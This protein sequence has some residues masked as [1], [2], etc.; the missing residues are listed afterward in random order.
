MAAITTQLT[1][2]LR[3]SVLDIAT[4]PGGAPKKAYQFGPPKMMAMWSNAPAA[5]AEPAA[6]R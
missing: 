5:M 4:K 3:E 6:R 1:T 2:G